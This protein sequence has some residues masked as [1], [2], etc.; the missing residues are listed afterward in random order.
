MYKIC[1]RLIELGSTSNLADKIE[2]LFDLGKLTSEE[3]IDLKERLSKV[4]S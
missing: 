4:S 3:Y 1:R 2:K